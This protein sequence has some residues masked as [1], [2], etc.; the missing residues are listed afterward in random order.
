LSD[1]GVTT[2]A[3]ENYYDPGPGWQRRFACIFGGQALSLVGTTITQ[4]VLLWWIT[5]TTGDTRAIAMAGMAALLPQA[6]LGPL[7]G[8]FADRYNRRFILI[9]TDAV[10]A[11][12]MLVLIALFATRR[13]EMWHVYSMMCIRSSMH[14]FQAP[15][16]AASTPMLVPTDFIPR[17]A[18][19]SQALLGVM[20]IASAPLGALALS[21]LPISA[22]LYIDVFTAFLGIVPLLFFRIPQ[23]IPTRETRSQ[24]WFEFRQVINLVWIHPGLRRLYVLHAA[25]VLVIMPTYT[26][27]PLLVK[28]HF[29]GGVPQVAFIEGISGVGMVAGGIVVT[30]FPP[31]QRIVTMLLAF[32]LSCLAVALTALTPGP[33]YRLA[34]LWYMA[35]GFAYIYGTA[36]LNAVLQTVIPNALQGRA[37]ALLTTLAGITGPFG[38]V[39]VGLVGEIVGV[40]WLLVGVGTI[41]GIVTLTGFLSPS[42]LRLEQTRVEDL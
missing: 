7:G 1:I 31:K 4:F 39:G 41:A 34:L 12:C 10:S 9:L 6:L 32:T 38:L 16:A 20:A 28:E 42:L 3:S 29:K 18:G 24:V 27:I 37:M 25:A 5:D 2:S 13:E 36:P 30:L 14:A 19:L 35:C 17:A 22:A 26:M 23:Q 15:A 8:T 11:C 33:L 21:L 40:R